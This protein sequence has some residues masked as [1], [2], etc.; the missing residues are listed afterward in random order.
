LDRGKKMPKFSE[1]MKNLKNDLIQ[2]AEATLQMMENSVRAILEGKEELIREVF[3]KED[4]INRKEVEIEEKAIEL[5]ARFQPEAQ[6]LRT[7]VMVLKI[8]NDLERIA[9]HAVNIA[10]R[11]SFLIKEPPVK[12][13]IDLPRMA[14]ITKKMLSDALKSFME[15]DSKLAKSV[16]ERDD[17]VDNLYFQIFRE[18]LTY[19]MQDPRV[20]ER[21]IRIVEVAKNI[22][23]IADLATNLSEDVIYIVDGK[24]IKHRLTE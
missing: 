23:R 5:M 16:C 18:L 19:M 10:R 21:S 6:N 20:I 12:P 9:D 15:G 13:Y 8:N 4:E 2:M 24:I 3:E 14:E 22:E 1:S 17:L 7:L 11:A